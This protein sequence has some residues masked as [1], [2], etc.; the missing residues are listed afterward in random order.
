MCSIAVAS[1]G[2]VRYCLCRGDFRTDTNSLALILAQLDWTHG[3]FSAV[4]LCCC[5]L[6]VWLISGVF[7]ATAD[8]LLD[9]F[10]EECDIAAVIELF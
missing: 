10:V 7:A 6:S 1:N 3:M 8:M 2:I 4:V 5:Q 9:E